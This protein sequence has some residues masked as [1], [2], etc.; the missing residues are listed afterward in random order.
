[1]DEHDGFTTTELSPD[2]RKIRVPGV[3]VVFS[4]ACE[5]RD[6]VCSQ[7]VKHVGDFFQ[8]GIGVQEGREG[9]EEAYPCGSSSLSLAT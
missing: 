3:M 6:A 7:V 4:V 2:R 1:M 8:A 5:E 9:A